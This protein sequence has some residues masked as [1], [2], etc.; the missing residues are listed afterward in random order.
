MVF[1]LI[2]PDISLCTRFDND[3]DIEVD[4]DST[5]FDAGDDENDC[6]EIF[7]EKNILMTHAE[8]PINTWI[9]AAI[10]HGKPVED[11]EHDVDVLPTKE[12]TL[13]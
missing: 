1:R 4:D 13:L 8:Y 2:M 5:D 6:D 9:V 3:D 12:K 7:F 11:K 10:T